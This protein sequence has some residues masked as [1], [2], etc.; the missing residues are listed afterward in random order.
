MED[1]NIESHVLLHNMF[2]IENGALLTY[3]NVI[4]LSLHV[5]FFKEIQSMNWIL[6]QLKYS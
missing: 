1:H 3:L 4:N 6:S 5:F 2:C